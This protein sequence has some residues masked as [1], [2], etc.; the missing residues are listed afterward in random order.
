MRGGLRRLVNIR[1]IISIL[2]LVFIGLFLMQT[3][4]SNRHVNPNESQFAKDSK[5]IDKITNRQNTLLK[6]KTGV[7]RYFSDNFDNYGELSKPIEQFED[8]KS[9]S[10]IGPVGDLSL[11]D[12][13][14]NGKH[15]LSVKVKKRNLND[16]YIIIRRQLPKPI[17]L[18]RWR[19]SGYL[20]L[21]LN[22]EDRAGI[23]GVSLRVGDNAN[24]YREYREL[25]NLQIAW[26]N[27]YDSDDPYPN[28]EYPVKD[29]ATDEW[30]DFWLA[31]GWN[32]LLWRMDASY[33]TESGKP[34]LEA[35]SWIEISIRI[36]RN[37]KPQ[38][39]L[40]DDLRVQ[41][42]LQKKTNPLDG[43][44]YPPH[45]RPQYGIFSI[46]R[47]GKDTALK[48]L[49]VRQTQYPSNGDHGRM[50]LSAGTPRDFTMRTRFM[51]TNLTKS[52]KQRVNT[53]FR[54]MYDFDPVWDPGHDWFGAY[55]SFEWDRFG[56]ITVKPVERFLIQEQEPKNEDIAISSKS[57]TPEANQ[58]Y[59]LHLTVR[60]QRATATL[61][62]VKDA[63]LL[64]RSKVDYVFERPRYGNNRRYPVTLE[65]TGNVKAIIYEVEIAKL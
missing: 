49:N 45:G 58:L 8:L 22:I 1:L 2:A 41:D 36:N 61:Y 46:D 4:I 54:M 44:W 39:I 37:I 34:D 50:I 26:P 20:T 31:K 62:E 13:C 25:P 43:I 53:W 27:N 35:I 28:L 38:E 3:Y 9:I 18:K 42:G 16:K 52:S 32:F 55:I 15:S 33:F 24:H 63:S 19:G 59:E 10:T 21:W 47:Y 48:L 30:T 11:S 60:G 65:I 5:S 64:L 12:N 23:D 6:D 40:L 56:L 7:I 57:F 51:F 17:D 14:Y 29:V